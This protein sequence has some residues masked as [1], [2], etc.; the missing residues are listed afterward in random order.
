MGPLATVEFLRKLVELTPAYIDQ[1]HIPCIIYSVPQVPCR[2]RAILDG[3]PSPLPA[4]L[5]GIRTLERA[6]AQAESE[7]SRVRGGACPLLG[8]REGPPR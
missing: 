6:G 8:N 2:V 4:L 7:S 5:T 1:D 3:G